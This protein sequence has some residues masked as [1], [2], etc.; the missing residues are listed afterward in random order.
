[1]SSSPMEV[2]A[3]TVEAALL[4]ASAAS[5]DAAAP[6]FRG[7]SPLGTQLHAAAGTGLRGPG[8]ARAA[9]RVRTSIFGTFWNT[10]EYGRI[11]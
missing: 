10:V 4:G 8:G 5:T 2:E 9:G 1:M 11:P 3:G 6:Q 7:R